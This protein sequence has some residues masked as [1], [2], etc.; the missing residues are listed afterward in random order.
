[1]T[2]YGNIRDIFLRKLTNG[3]GSRP[4]PLMEDSGPSKAK[5]ASR[6]QPKLHPRAVQLAELESEFEFESQ[7]DHQRRPF[8]AGQP[9]L[10]RRR[11]SGLPDGA[12][13]SARAMGQG[14]DPRPGQRQCPKRPRGPADHQPERFIGGSGEGDYARPIGGL[15]QAFQSLPRL[16]DAE[17]PR[18]AGRVEQHL[19]AAADPTRE[20]LRRRSFASVEIYQR[21]AVQQ[22]ASGL[23]RRH[24]QGDRDA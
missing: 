2:P 20:R 11:R 4:Q 5:Y 19:A 18:R 8:G 12:R 16:G 7:R 23:R 3:Q 6:R 14:R 21:G 9:E 24:H 10:G 15:Q 13:G 17:R 1:M 22:P